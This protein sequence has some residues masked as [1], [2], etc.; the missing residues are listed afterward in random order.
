MKR[1]IPLLFFMSAVILL[2]GLARGAG[3]QT[4]TRMEVAGEAPVLR[5]NSARAFQNALRSA[6]RNA[7]TQ[8]VRGN[9]AEKDFVS[10]REEIEN[11]LLRTS[12]RFIQRYRLLGQRLDPATQRLRVKLEVVIDRVRINGV[13]RSLRLQTKNPGEVRVLILVEEQILGRSRTPLP[14][15]PDRAGTAERRMM[16]RFAQAG[17]TPISPRAQRQPAAPGQIA[18]AVRGNNDT[19]R[20]LGG[21][22]RCD[23]VVTAR[24]IAERERG[25]AYV[26]LVNARV[27]RVSDGAVLAIRSRQVRL[28]PRGSGSG[29]DAV[30]SSASDRVALALVAEM[31]RAALLRRGRGR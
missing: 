30:L 11:A 13:L 5:Q 1:I 23:L 31:R 12:A 20:T 18:A 14:L 19:A 17:Y 24:A 16:I 8:V 9:M 4:G 26:G 3:H 7:V 21:I 6:F 10:F 25:G 15:P 22:C 29:F 27:L 2:G 28:R